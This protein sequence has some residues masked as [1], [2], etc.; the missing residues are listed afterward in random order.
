MNSR[1]QILEAQK[2][3]KEEAEQRDRDLAAQWAASFAAECDEVYSKCEELA[4]EK[5]MPVRLF[6]EQYILN[7]KKV[8]AKVAAKPAAESR[9]YVDPGNS[10]VTWSGKGPVPG[11]FVKL[12]AEWERESLRE[13]NTPKRL[14]KPKPNGAS[15]TPAATH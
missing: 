14:D 8:A 11:P 13:G 5:D 3:A 7:R 12:F 15:A 9:P 4:K 2:K 6:I 10:K 1:Q